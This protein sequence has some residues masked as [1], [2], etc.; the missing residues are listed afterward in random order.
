MER[1]FVSSFLIN[2]WFLIVVDI[3][4]KSFTRPYYLERCLY[5]IYKFAVG[6]FRVQV[7]DDGTLPEYLARIKQLFP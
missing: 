1:L 6:D 4:I 5:S 2:C 7:L 3:V